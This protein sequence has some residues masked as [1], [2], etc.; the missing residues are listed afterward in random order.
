MIPAILVLL[1]FY[2][3][4][5]NIW[6]NR[7]DGSLNQEIND[8]PVFSEQSEPEEEI[9]INLN[10]ATKEELTTLSGIGEKLAERI[11]EKRESLGGFRSVEQ[12][13]E[14]PGIGEKLFQQIQSQITIE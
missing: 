12:I 1:S 14:I 8:L 10:T 2:F 13:T 6:Q 11:L 7:V 9:K 4:G 3:W 5:L